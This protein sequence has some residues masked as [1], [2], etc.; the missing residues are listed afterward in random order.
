MSALLPAGK[1]V[2]PTGVPRRIDPTHPIL[3]PTMWKILTIVAALFTA[4]GAYL[5]FDNKNLLA[6]EKDLLADA[7]GNLA[8]AEKHD[9]EVRESAKEAEENF[10]NL[11]TEYAK[12]AEELE[13]LKGEVETKTAEVD[14]E[15]A[16]LK[17]QQ[18]QL[19]TISDQ[20]K[21]LGTVREA[22]DT[23]KTLREDVSSLKTQVT[24]LKQEQSTVS[25]SVISTAERIEKSKLVEQWQ[26]QGKMESI[27]AR[28]SM[29]SPEYGFVVIGA[30]N[31]Q[32]VVGE[33]LLDVVRGSEAI[34]TLKVVVLEGNRSICDVVSLAPG[35]TIQAGD[36]LYV[37]EASKPGSE[38][39][40]PVATTTPSGGG[41]AAAPPADGAEPMADDPAGDGPSMDD[42]P[43]GD[44]EPPAIDSGGGDAAGGGGAMDDN[45]FGL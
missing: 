43:F 34:A 25:N 31:N 1:K 44:L 8:T 14:R 32:G 6:T 23:L 16:T 37:N 35:Q 41:G 38:P 5:A 39:I 36:R 19:A 2:I 27:S 33:A 21:E 15:K 30:G 40:I 26:T 17:T 20:V 9:I 11:T 10:D 24:T 22:K 7:K 28:V 13:K 29:V 4:A 18:D 45:P 12:L 3:T 42:N